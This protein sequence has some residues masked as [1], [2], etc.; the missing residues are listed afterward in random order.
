MAFITLPSL[1][2]VD[3]LSFWH[4]VNTYL[5]ASEHQTAKASAFIEG[6]NDY[7][8]KSFVC[9]FVTRAFLLVYRS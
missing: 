5:S 2:T 1:M 7:K 4:D 3:V 6:K 9:F 8:L